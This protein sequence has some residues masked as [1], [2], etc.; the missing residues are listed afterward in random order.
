MMYTWWYKWNHE[1]IM[2][3][4]ITNSQP[5]PNSNA[6]IYEYQIFSLVVL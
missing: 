2:L 3:S 4:E 5:V 1:N 6:D